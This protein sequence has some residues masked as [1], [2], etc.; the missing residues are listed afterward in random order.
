MGGATASVIDK[1]EGGKVVLWKVSSWFLCS[2]AAAWS[3]RACAHTKTQRHTH[4]KKINSATYSYHHRHIQYSI[5][6]RKRY[7]PGDSYINRKSHRVTQQPFPFLCEDIVGELFEGQK[8]G[9]STVETVPVCVWGESV[10]E[11]KWT[12]EWKHSSKHILALWSCV[13]VSGL[14]ITT[15]ITVDDLIWC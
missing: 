9:H 13:C 3:A 8:T 4:V 14:I 10:Y 11:G 15:V 6:V 1:T 2:Q 5:C 7:V 12:H